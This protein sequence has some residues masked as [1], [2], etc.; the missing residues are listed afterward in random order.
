MD[1][2]LV[3]VL[4][5]LERFVRSGDGEVVFE[6]EADEEVRNLFR[7]EPGATAVGILF[8]WFN[9]CRYLVLDGDEALSVLAVV[10]DCFR[11]EEVHGDA[12]AEIVRVIADCDPRELDRLRAAISDS[13]VESA[14]EVAEQLE[15]R[16][17]AEPRDLPI[18]AAIL[19]EISKHYID[20]AH[21]ENSAVTYAE[22]V[23]VRHLAVDLLPAEHPG[24]AALLTKLAREVAALVSATDDPAHLDAAIEIGKQ[25]IL[26][27]CDEPDDR[28]QQLGDLG[29]WLLARFVRGRRDETDLR[30]AIDVLRQYLHIHQQ[31]DAPVRDPRHAEN[32]ANLSLALELSAGRRE[33][34]SALDEAIEFSRQGALAAPDGDANRVL[35]QLIHAKQRRTRFT[36]SGDLTDLDRAVAVAREAAH[37]SGSLTSGEVYLDMLIEYHQATGRPETLDEAVEWAR[38]HVTSLPEDADVP[39]ELLIT[40]AQTFHNDYHRSSERSSLDEAVRLAGRA[41]AA[42]EQDDRWR[43]WT[44]LGSI[45]RTEH[46]LTKDVPTIDAAISAQRSA[47]EDLDARHVHDPNVRLSFANALIQKCEVHDDPSVLGEAIDLLRSTTSTLPTESTRG[48]AWL[49]LATALIARHDHLSDVEGLD[50]ARTALDNAASLLPGEHPLRADLTRVHEGIVARVQS[51][52]IDHWL[53]HEMEH[54]RHGYFLSEFLSRGELDGLD[55]YLASL[56]GELA[57]PAAGDGWWATFSFQL[58]QALLARF[59]LARQPAD[60][61]EAIGVFEQLADRPDVCSS[62]RIPDLAV[63]R[64]LAR[65]HVELRVADSMRTGMAMLESV[66]RRSV[67]DPTARGMDLVILGHASTM[68]R[69]LDPSHP[70]D[71]AV[72]YLREAVELA[73]R[74]DNPVWL[75]RALAQLSSALLELADT[76]GDGAEDTVTAA[77]DAATRAL[78]IGA[79]ADVWVGSARLYL[80]TAT[81]RLGAALA[82]CMAILEPAVDTFG[83]ASEV[84]WLARHQTVGY[85]HTL[86]DESFDRARADQAI[87][88]LTVLASNTSSDDRLLSCQEGLLRIHAVL[89]DL[90]NT[91]SARWVLENGERI[92]EALHSRGRTKNWWFAIFWTA[93]AC[94]ADYSAERGETI[95][96]GI[97][98]LRDLEKTMAQGELAQDYESLHPSLAHVLA[99]LYV[100]RQT[101]DRGTNVELAIAALAPYNSAEH[102][103][104][105]PATWAVGQVTRGHVLLHRTRGSVAENT[106]EAISALRGAVDHLPAVSSDLH[107]ASASLDLAA[108]LLKKL[109]RGPS[110]ETAADASNAAEEALRTFTVD[111]SRGGR[112]RGLEVFAEATL[113]RAESPTP[114]HLEVAV[115]AVDE[116]LSLVDPETETTRAGSLHFT[117]G[118]ALRHRATTPSEITAVLDEFREAVTLV[119]RVGFL[120]NVARMAYG[121]AGAA[122]D[123][124]RWEDAAAFYRIG[125]R[126]VE[127]LYQTPTSESGKLDELATIWGIHIDAVL[128]FAH[129]GQLM[130]AVGAAE[131]GRARTLSDAVEQ[132]RLEQEIRT[133]YPSEY[134]AFHNARTA[135][136]TITQYDNARDVEAAAD[137]HHDAVAAI[138]ALP[139]QADF[140]RPPD[141]PDYSTLL[142]DEDVA[143]VYIDCNDKECVH[144]VV[145][146]G[147]CVR[148]VWTEYARED[149]RRSLFG[150]DES[151]LPHSLFGGTFIGGEHLK[152]ALDRQLAPIGA[153]LVAPLAAAL[154]EQ[155]I[156]RVI[157]LPGGP[158]ALLPLHA[159]PLDETGRC[160]LDLVEVSYGPSARVLSKVAER[161]E[162]APRA[163]VVGAPKGDLYYAAQEARHVAELFDER[164]LLGAEATVRQ[165]RAGLREATDVHLACHAVYVPMD[166]LTSRIELADGD[167]TLGDLLGERLFGAGPVVVAS[168]CQSATSNQFVATDEQ[169]SLLTGFLRSGASSVVATLWKIPDAPAAY[170]M[171]RYYHER[172]EG[173]T[174]AESLRDAQRWIRD[175]TTATL[176]AFLRDIGWSSTLVMFNE[177]DTRPLAHPV[178]WAPFIIVGR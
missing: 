22:A 169:L 17:S 105:D 43:A 145:T 62:A 23:R 87:A 163:L 102:R 124:E 56:R 125:L 94:R 3:A 34:A 9:W 82:D 153:R 47:L 141:V 139:G 33:T 152:A 164:P 86:L 38:L 32:L 132:Q 66:Q 53:R 137:A 59:E 142:T 91:A 120:P 108:A 113:R 75:V 20:H 135:L 5:R 68:L 138:R 123:V 140:L 48:E 122:S 50:S 24:R 44:T 158:L 11:P 156:R 110:P 36:R 134:T 147:P 93:N 130:A 126:A 31:H 49:T 174:A 97:R 84:G 85:L 155:G 58:G 4:D 16:L 77:A 92:A 78:A 119:Q 168:A 106:E 55:G 95:D 18:P 171:A 103:R 143:L 89:A 146:A 69:A 12:P 73:D 129:A 80:A 39:V 96:K 150:A 1:S 161:K 29:D 127:D 2:R 71:V 177:T 21:A 165:V 35:N 64:H 116:A 90:E 107:R 40:A 28:L 100:A 109:E 42:S 133:L 117:R 166:P 65:A 162:G 61:R 19:I 27:D 151:D 63:E 160:L 10:V 76:T 41:S 173:K 149:M 136:A 118:R 131:L 70:A 67:D 26:V 159:A 8:G 13:D 104:R 74:L 176:S 46:Q 167:L 157:L 114:E 112:L 30:D 144:L 148:P 45:L 57:S 51:L 14:V 79:S 154:E 175:C 83:A 60:L 88:M 128:A 7:V 99:T 54:D 170:L 37:E 101:G 111:R 72:A 172:A 6:P 178:N 25:A 81:H 52:P 98:L 121:G 115:A 15:E